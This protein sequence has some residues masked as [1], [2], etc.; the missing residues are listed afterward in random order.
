MNGSKIFELYLKINAFLKSICD[1][2]IRN[3]HF[4]Q[5]WRN[6]L[7]LNYT[8][9]K[10]KSAK[11][12]VSYSVWDGEELLENSI[13]S[14]RSVVDYIQVVYQKK[15]W[16]GVPA[17]SDLIPLLTKL[18][19]K[20]LI[21]ELVEFIPDIT[22]KP[23]INELRK[24]NLGLKVAKK[25][26]VNYFMTMDAD[27]FYIADDLKRAKIDMIL[28]GVTHLY[29][30]IKCYGNRPTDYLHIN[31]YFVQLFAKI[32]FFSK[33]CNNPNVPCL[34]DPTRKISGSVF[35]K[36]WV[37]ELVSMHHMSLV[38]N[39]LLKKYKNSSSNAVR[40]EKKK[41]VDHIVATVP[42]IFNLISVIK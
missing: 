42:D 6:Y 16:F 40:N 37:S 27:E 15:S 24:R 30:P 38:R 19:N 13:K 22:N 29:A 1:K 5:R 41:K 20:G 3:K 33:C 34:V 21:D 36:Y 31:S 7:I 25:R 11:W 23:G 12:G 17:N 14:I 28:N 32:N 4:R 10:V 2:R 35:S 26:K 9:K 8:I 39:N 18:K